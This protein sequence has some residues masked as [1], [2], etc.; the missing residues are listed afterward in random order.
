MPISRQFVVRSAISLLAVG[1]AALI[2]IIAATIWL[3]ERVQVHF[4]DVIAARETRTVAVELRSALQ[5]AES[6]QRGFLTSG[7]EIYLAPYDRAKT[8]AVRQLQMLRPAI[9]TYDGAGPLYARLSQVVGEKIAEMDQTIALLNERKPEDALRLF[10]TNRGKVL[11]DEA[12]VFLSGIIRAADERL[13]TS[14]SDQSTNA[15]WLRW[16]STLGAILIVFV[17]GVVV[18]I[19]GRYAREIATARDEVRLANTNL[20][21]RVSERTLDLARA[22]ERAETLLSEVNHRVANSL[23]LVASMVRLQSRSVSGHAAKTA[24]AETEARINAVAS[25]HRKLYSSDSVQ[26]VA[27]NEFLSGILDNLAGVMRDEGRTSRLQ[28]DLERIDLPTDA[29]VN[30]GVIA[31]EW[32]TNAFKYAYPT[33]G[34]DIRVL[35]KRLPDERGELAVEDRGVGRSG[36]EAPQGT[37][38]GTRIVRAMADSI[39]G[40]IAYEDRSPGTTARLVFPLRR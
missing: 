4:K 28:Y 24:L 21:A 35:L 38:L 15:S 27:L 10:R 26:S 3:G 2:A 17:V 19:L 11:M 31:T 29:S 30:L 14:A 36:R 20:E 33:E 13:I 18:T 12:N 6:S 16:I 37:G 39:K 1:F 7:N 9:E 25:V 32:V 23:A 8:I 34:G 40:D 5:A 22:K